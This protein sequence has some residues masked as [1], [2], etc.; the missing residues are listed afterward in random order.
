MRV[1]FFKLLLLW[2]ERFPGRKGE[3]SDAVR[4]GIST[5]M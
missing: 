4:K 1:I 3:T 5:I 2:I